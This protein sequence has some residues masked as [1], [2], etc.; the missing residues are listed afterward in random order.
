[1]ALVD[2]LAAALALRDARHADHQ[3]PPQTLPP[4]PLPSS[5]SSAWRVEYASPADC[6]ARAIEHA[7][8]SA[9]VFWSTPFIVYDTHR[10]D[11]AV[12]ACALRFAAPRSMTAASVALAP[13][14]YAAFEARAM[15][16]LR[17]LDDSDAKSVAAQ[18][19]TAACVPR[20]DECVP[21]NEPVR[22]VRVQHRSDAPLH[23]QHAYVAVGD[24]LLGHSARPL[25]LDVL[26][27]SFVAAVRLRCVEFV[28][29]C[30]CYM[31]DASRVPLATVRSALKK[32]SHAADDALARVAVAWLRRCIATRY[33]HAPCDREDIAAATRALDIETLLVVLEHRGAATGYARLDFKSRALFRVVCEW[34][35]ENGAPRGHALAAVYA[36]MPLRDAVRETRGRCEAWL[37]SLPSIYSRD[38]VSEALRNVELGGGE[39]ATTAATIAVGDA[40]FVTPGDPFIDSGR[41][42]EV[43]ESGGDAFATLATF[44]AQHGRNDRCTTV[45]LPVSQLRKITRRRARAFDLVSVGAVHRDALLTSLERCAR[46]P[47]DLIDVLGDASVDVQGC[48][49]RADAASVLVSF[50]ARP[51]LGAVAVPYTAVQLVRRLPARVGARVMIAASEL[52][53]VVVAVEDECIARVRVSDDAV[54]SFDVTCHLSALVRAPDEE[55]DDE[56]EE[57]KE[58]EGEREENED[59]EDE[60]GADAEEEE[61]DDGE[62]LDEAEEGEDDEEDDDVDEDYD[63]FD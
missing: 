7:L 3:P 31:Y 35:E 29:R 22:P 13:H 10:D 51:E 2:P 44:R 6:L 24:Y 21:V 47:D 39:A 40:V 56:E 28:R 50:A 54:E 25:S 53:G 18:R 30:V 52:R 27:V 1:M 62:A 57:E 12:V 19:C 23:D 37:D 5:S 48:V 63:G 9:S 58:E 26:V 61:E 42:L 55:E 11:E 36:H 59:E 17:A 41:V 4:Q 15:A 16:A 45:W 60:R 34:C 33:V 43:R 8:P 32:V 38:E 14:A 46:V 20:L 49:V